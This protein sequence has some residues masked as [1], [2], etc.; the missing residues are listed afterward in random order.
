[1]E[2][3]AKE[4]GCAKGLVIYHFQSKARLLVEAS[5]RI[6]A[7]LASRRA[8]AVKRGVR[9]APAL[10]TLWQGIVS[11]VEDGSF[12]AW[13]E[14]EAWQRTA[15][16]GRPA[17]G[18]GTGLRAAISQALDV[19]ADQLPGAAALA[20]VL[21]GLALQL[22]RGDPRDEVERAYHELWLGVLNG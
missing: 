13:V 5:Q 8:A 10:D 19:P 3:V 2:R 18:D 16:P 9:G 21:D 22:M 15:A 4:A 6:G 7:D 17:A 12:G 11:Q 14:L 20:A 1:M